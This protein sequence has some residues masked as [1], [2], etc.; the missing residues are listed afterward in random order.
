[1]IEKKW[2]RDSTLF[3]YPGA[4]FTLQSKRTQLPNEPVNTC[5]VKLSGIVSMP[6]QVLWS[7]QLIDF[8]WFR[9]FS[10]VYN[11]SLLLRIVVNETDLIRIDGISEIIEL[12][13]VKLIKMIAI[14]LEDNPEPHPW[15]SAGGH[16][17]SETSNAGSKIFD[18]WSLNQRLILKSEIAPNDFN[19]FYI[20][21]DPENVPKVF[22]LIFYSLGRVIPAV[23]RSKNKRMTWW[24]ECP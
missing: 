13:K 7:D 22:L 24:L 21:W 5:L 8:S 9:D 17:P 16:R 12:L 10:L 1:M 4:L 19:M 2:C 14:N 23:R 18:V 15:F 11:T 20:F 3:V 6:K